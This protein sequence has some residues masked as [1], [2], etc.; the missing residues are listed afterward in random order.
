MRAIVLVEGRGCAIVYAPGPTD[1]F[2]VDARVF[3]RGALTW[4]RMAWHLACRDELARPVYVADT[5]AIG[6]PSWPFSHLLHPEG[7]DA[8]SAKTV[9]WVRL[10]QQQRE[11]AS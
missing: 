7:W 10:R 1:T 2:S 5:P 4:K 8:P 9:A 3:R 6:H 11:R